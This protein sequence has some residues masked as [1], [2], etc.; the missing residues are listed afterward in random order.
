MTVIKFTGINKAGR[1][2]T[3]DVDGKTVVR[4]I[5]KKFTGTIDDH[6]NAL[7]RGLMAEAQAE[8]VT[9]IETPKAKAGEVLRSNEEE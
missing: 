8:D 2:A 4:K 6:L 7:A 1:T 9:A 3:F 5:P